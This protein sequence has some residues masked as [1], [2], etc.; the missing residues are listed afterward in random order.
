MIT[1]TC[2]VCNQSKDLPYVYECGRECQNCHKK[3]LRKERGLRKPGPKPMETP[4]SHCPQG[5]ALT[6][7]NLL[8]TNETRETGAKRSRA[9]CKLCYRHQSVKRL[10]G[11]TVEQYDAMLVV[12]NHACPICLRPFDY[13]QPRPVHVDHCHDGGQVRELLCLGC[14]TGLGNFKH[15][16]EALRRAA[17]YLDKHTAPGLS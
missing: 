10:Y 4:P 17:S 1:G 11:L 8:W 9:R 6:E 13:E 14:N 12:Q 5:H 15:D 7:D 3:R 16:A 2:V